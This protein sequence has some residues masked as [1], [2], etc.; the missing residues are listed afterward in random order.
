MSFVLLKKTTP[1]SLFITNN[2]IFTFNR[3]FICHLT[4]VQH[5]LPSSNSKNFLIIKIFLLTSSYLNLVVLFIKYYCYYFE[6]RDKQH[7]S[8]NLHNTT[9]MY[10]NIYVLLVFLFAVLIK[11]NSNLL[12]NKFCYDV[13]C[14][15]IFISLHRRLYF[16]LI[17]LYF[18]CFLKDLLFYF[19]I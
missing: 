2:T 3:I 18:F 19:F 9:Y 17:I 7:N 4:C 12:A 14:C 16:I 15:V 6:E 1:I 13:V 8:Y 10:Y 5:I 11:V